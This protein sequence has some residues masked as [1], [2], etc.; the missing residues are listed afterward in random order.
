MVLALLKTGPVLV[1]EIVDKLAGRFFTCGAGMVFV[2]E[3]ICISTL[4]ALVL[5]AYATKVALRASLAVSLGHR[6]WIC[7][8][9]II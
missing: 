8:I 6:I 1:W 7:T 2:H 5:F 4:L 9:A 3:R